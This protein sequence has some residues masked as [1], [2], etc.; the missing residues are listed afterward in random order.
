MNEQK[1]LN[2]EKLDDEKK[3]ELQGEDKNKEPE[4]EE[5]K[6]IYNE[7]EERKKELKAGLKRGMRGAPS[8]DSGDNNEDK[9][10]IKEP[11]FKFKTIVMLLFLVAL[12]LSM[13]NFFSKSNAYKA[14]EVTYTEFLNMLK[15]GEFKALEEKDGYLYADRE[16]DQKKISARMITNRIAD[17]SNIMQ[18]AAENE[19]VI[20]S[21]AD[22][23]VPLLVNVLI[24]WFPMLLLIGVW[25]FM[26]NKMN[27]GSGGGPQIFNMGK[28]R[29]KENGDQIS[30]VTFKDVAGIEEAK[31]EL[32][33]V[34]HFL[35]EPE[36]YKRIGARIPKGVL[37][38][39]A[40]GTGKTLLA[41]AVAGEA[42]VPFFSISGSEF[43]EMFVGVGA[44][45]VRDLFGKARKSAPCIIF[46]DEIDAVGRKRGAG[47][48]GGNDEREQTLNQ[49]LVEMD[50]FGTDETII[51]LA[52]TN[53]PEI[54]DKALMR[55]GRFDRQVVVDSPDINGRLE[56]L[57]VH[58]RG[59]KIAKDVDLH[60]LARKTVG[61]VGA[62]LANL[63]NEAAI[64]AARE[65]REEVSM[66]DLE[67]AAEKVTI[68][69]ERKS[70]VTVQKERVTVAYHE[71]GHALVQWV[72]PNTDAVHKVT[73][74]PR[75]MAALGYTMSLPA[76]DRY[77]K[78]KNEYLSEL[79]T[80]LGGRAAEEI[81][82]G[83]ITTGAGN[84]IERATK[85]AH[86][87]VTKFGMSEKF[88]PLLLDDSHEG[89]IF[90]QK[91]HSDETG[92]EIDDEVRRM[93]SE[94]Y[95]GAKD[96]LND[97]R[98]KL[99]FIAKTLLER[100]T[101]SGEELDKL[102]KGEELEEL[103]KKSVKTGPKIE[104]EIKENIETD[105][106]DASYKIEPGEEGM[107][108]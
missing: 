65:G 34:V 90:K 36:T 72:L 18:T 71:V 49:L 69:P 75:G 2:E 70:R 9:K 101:I 16:S 7:L 78:T 17:D 53:R 89:D 22:A 45:R 108:G 106:S 8:Q 19:I 57:K 76:E 107:Q 64:L 102:M 32:E 35:K 23:E 12:I 20:K 105:E 87:M 24:S 82:F 37:L 92:K 54:L 98:E 27:K 46:I 44:S 95:T 88:G 31:E 96:I 80:L 5:E 67:E 93:I 66:E 13:P 10:P 62:D 99:E 91:I 15:E 103:K 33:E 26:L 85:M 29:A 21:S 14:N 41:K 42:G 1:D 79:K 94:A 30:D 4:Q 58:I 86:A 60:T 74:V 56:I 50:G 48:G 97:N 28:S 59:K 6:E 63:L 52:A 43:V 104:E 61:F 55:P 84:D 39:G 11:K 68:G 25:I 83:D 100:E 51:V 73:I 3:E 81:I 77:L 47:Q 40:P 38:L